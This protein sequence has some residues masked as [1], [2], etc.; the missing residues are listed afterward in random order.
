M[1]RRVDTSGSAER[2]P[3]AFA[4]MRR[5]L[6]DATSV[7]SVDGELDL[8][9]SPRLKWMLVECI[10]AGCERLVID[11]SHTTFM[12]STALGVLVGINRRLGEGRLAIV[13]ARETLL[14][15][16]ELSGT[17]RVFAINPT[18]DEALAHVRGRLAQ[19]G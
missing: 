3:A 13:C 1:L 4:V 8:A 19:A 6:E 14:D 17:A 18:L 16:F 10:E 11:L 5:D 15:I 12:D 7:V 2:R 9:S